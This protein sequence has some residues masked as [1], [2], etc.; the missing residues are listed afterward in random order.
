MTL[1][2]KVSV[3]IYLKFQSLFKSIF[4]DKYIKSYLKTAVTIKKV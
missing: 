1:I 3:F 2:K 4:Y